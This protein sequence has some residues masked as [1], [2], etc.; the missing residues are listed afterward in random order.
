MKTNELKKGTMVLLAN[1]WHG[2]LWDNARGNTRIVNVYGD[3]EEAGS[4]YSHDI[5]AFATQQ[6]NEDER[7]DKSDKY[8][9]KWI[10]DIEYTPSQI[11]CRE[12]V[13]AMGF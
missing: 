11:A 6:V 3:F 10:T 13:R 7:R 8:A 12:A 2:E 5:V 1:G 4:V 9:W